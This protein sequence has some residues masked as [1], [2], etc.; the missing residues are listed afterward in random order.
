LEAVEGL[1]SAS[2]QSEDLKVFQAAS[3]F[4]DGAEVGSS[5]MGLILGIRGC[6]RVDLWMMWVFGPELSDV[7][8][9]NHQGG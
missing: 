3:D 6:R 1:S 8:D 5:E 2:D 9:V 4:E 7:R